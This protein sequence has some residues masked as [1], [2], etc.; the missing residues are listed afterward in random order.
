MCSAANISKLSLSSSMNES[1]D[2]IEISLL[3]KKPPFRNLSDI[4]ELNPKRS[5][6]N[7]F[8]SNRFM[9]SLT[10]DNLTSFFN[11][12]LIASGNS[13]KPVNL[14]TEGIIE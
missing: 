10:S 4:L 3:P 11:D 14:C 5:N 1:K 6:G 9:N 12:S 2:L 8:L 13:S 7:E